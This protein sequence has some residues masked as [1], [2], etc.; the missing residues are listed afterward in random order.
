MLFDIS[1]VH[2]KI[3]GAPALKTSSSRQLGRVHPQVLFHVGSRLRG[4]SCIPHR[5]DRVRFIASSLWTSPGWWVT[6]LRV[7][8]RT[9]GLRAVRFEG[10]CYEDVSEIGGWLVPVSFPAFNQFSS[11]LLDSCAPCLGLER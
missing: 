2:G 6:S 5:I 3:S 9:C 4:P 7:T 8:C 11:M 1:A 10:E